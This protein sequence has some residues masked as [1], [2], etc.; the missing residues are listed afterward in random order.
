MS[1]IGIPITD[2][3]AKDPRQ[4]AY[5]AQRRKV[6]AAAIAAYQAQADAKGEPTL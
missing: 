5:E 1:D 3:D 2:P 6:R 4:V